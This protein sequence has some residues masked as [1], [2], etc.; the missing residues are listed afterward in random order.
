MRVLGP[1]PGPGR[2]PAGRSRG[3]A[4][5]AEPALERPL[6]GPGG[7]RVHPSQFD[8]DADSPPAGVLAAE[9]QDRSQE[10][11]SR[12][13]VTPTGVIGGQELSGKATPGLRREGPLC[14]ISDCAHGQVELP[15]D[16]RRGG[17]ESGHPSDG[18][19]QREF[20]GAWHRS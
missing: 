1:L 12:R 18:E 8:V 17:P 14:Q 5:P 20:G 7:S 16:L 15:G 4:V 2:G 11:R 6:R 9:V 13:W 3:Q 19:P 10:W